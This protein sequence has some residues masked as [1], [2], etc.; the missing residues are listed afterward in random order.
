MVNEGYAVQTLAQ[1][2]LCIWNCCR[3]LKKILADAQVQIKGPD[4]QGEKDQDVEYQ[5]EFLQPLHS[6][7][8]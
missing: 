2:G 8:R 1:P 7:I 6:D 4:S 5:K 3:R